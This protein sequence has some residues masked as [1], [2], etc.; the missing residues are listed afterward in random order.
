MAHVAEELV[1]AQIPPHILAAMR[2]RMKMAQRMS[3]IKHKIV[4][5]SGKG[6][7][8]KCL[9]RGTAILTG[10][11]DW[12]SIEALGTPVV[13][14][15]EEGQAVIRQKTGITRRH[16][17]INILRLRSGRKLALTE[18]HMLYTYGRWRSLR[19]LRR[20]DRV[21]TIRWLPEPMGPDELTEDEAVV[22]GLLL[23]DGG[24][25]NG[26][27]GFTSA[28]GTIL[29]VLKGAVQH[30]DPSLRVRRRGRSPYGYTI[31][32][33]SRGGRRNA[34]MMLARRLQVDL[35]SPEKYLPLQVFRSSNKILT[36]V[37]RGLFSTD[38]SVYDDKIEF[39]SSSPKL[40]HDVQRALLRFGIHSVLR[41]RFPHYVYKGEKRPGLKSYRLLILG[42]DILTF[43]THIRF[44]GGKLERLR[45]AASK[46]ASRRRNPNMDTLPRDVWNEVEAESA[47]QKLSWAQLSKE[48]GYAQVRS[49][50]N[51]HTYLKQGYLDRRVCPSRDTLLKIASLLNSPRLKAIAQSNIYWDEV[52]AIEDGGM[53]EVFDVEVDGS[54]NFIAEGIL[55]HNSTVA[56]NLAVVLA[57]EGPVGLVDA[58]VTGPDIPKLMGV[59]DAHVK[60]TDTGLEPTVGP[61]GVRVISM[62]QLVDRDTAIV[63][64]GPLKIKAL[65][66]MLS[67][68]EWGELDYLVIDL[69]PGTSD[70]PLSVAQEIPD[71]DGAVVV[72]TPQEVSLLDVRKSIAFAKA[73]KMEILGV[74]ENMSGLVCPH[75]GESIDVFKVGG[76]EAAAKELGLPFLGRIPLDPRIVVGGDAGKPF[77]LEHPESEASKAFRT[78]VENLKGQLKT[79]QPRPT[80]PLAK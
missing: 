35:P 22:L 4:V 27:P 46:V 47:G 56:A 30:M 69:P 71:A 3:K 23:G 32:G 73:V 54:H 1:T 70:E 29:D 16:A 36:I 41:E 7:V 60:A 37:L 39:S 78:I 53:D 34:V 31:S 20:G 2:E 45:A 42:K 51:G 57:K 68:V 66:Q 55:V 43:A 24:L 75:C 40:A 49:T 17:G 67:D 5:M 77:V 58:D 72:T 8:G 59:E 13:S 21:A 26:V 80:G 11:G 64:R 33:G 74:V 15:D 19:D 18:D 44:W 76:G 10:Y 52:V 65:K 48:C 6:G 38:G 62:A 63:W 25:S 28:D 9:R 50:Y 79:P 12:Q 14:L 61:A